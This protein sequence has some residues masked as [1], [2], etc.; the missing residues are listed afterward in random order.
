MPQQYGAA[1]AVA[2]AGY[3]QVAR[4]AACG[5][6]TDVHTRATRA[7]GRLGV[8]CSPPVRQA[9][10]AVVG[11]EGGPRGKRATDCGAHSAAYDSHVAAPR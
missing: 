3:G 5:E 7:G 8:E 2:V 11:G 10:T 6:T 4:C 1:V 9:L